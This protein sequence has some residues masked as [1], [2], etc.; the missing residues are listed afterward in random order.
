[1]INPLRFIRA[2]QKIKSLDL[3]LFPHAGIRTPSRSR[4]TAKP[5]NSIPPDIIEAAQYASS[6]YK[7][8]MGLLLAILQLES[9]FSSSATSNK[10][11]KG[12]G[13]LMPST[14]SGCSKIA[15][16]MGLDV[17]T[18]QDREFA[19]RNNYFNI[20][21]G[22]K[23][24]KTSK[25]YAS[26]TPLLSDFTLV[27]YD[28]ELDGWYRAATAYYAGDVGSTKILNGWIK[29]VPDAQKWKPDVGFGWLDE[30]YDILVYAN[31]AFTLW[32]QYEFAITVGV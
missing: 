31:L 24:L 2:A 15:D 14:I 5:I 4:Y 30:N 17:E 22:A 6:R 26:R 7:V 10:G 16:E 1:M 25:Q 23:H 27:E 18:R 21:C 32:V 3:S 20:F 19:A 9:G 11:A 8:P 13:Q 28:Q 12:V 29:K